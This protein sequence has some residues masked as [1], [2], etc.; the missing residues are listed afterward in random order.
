MKIRNK[1]LLL[2]ISFALTSQLVNSQ[3][4]YYAINI[5]NNGLP[6]VGGNYHYTDIYNISAC[7]GQAV[8]LVAAGNSSCPS[9]YNPVY[10]Y[11]TIPN[12]T[13]SN[14]FSYSQGVCVIPNGQKIYIK[15]YTI[16]STID[17]YVTLNVCGYPIGKPTITGGTNLC[18]GN[19]ISTYSGASIWSI[20]PSNAGTLTN[21][22]NGTCTISWSSSFI[23]TAQLTGQNSTTCCGLSALSDP[24]SIT[25]NSVPSSPIAS[26]SGITCVG[27]TLSLSSSTITGATYNWTGPNGY[28][29]T[30]QNPL[31]SDNASFLMA[32]NYT[33]TANVNGCINTP[34]T[35]S[36][37]INQATINSNTTVCEGTTLSLT[38]SNIP[39]ASYF[40]TG[41]NGFSSIDQNP[42][43]SL[44]VNSNMAGTYNVYTTANSCTSPVPGTIDIVVIPKPSTPIPSS[45]GPVC[46]GNNLSLS[47]PTILGATYQWTGPNSFSSTDQNPLIST[48]ASAIMGGI[49]NLTTTINGCSSN[50]S[51]TSVQINKIT[52]SSNGPV[53]SGKTLSLGATAIIGATYSWTGPNG[54]TS[55]QQNPIVSTNSTSAMAGVYNV[56]STVNGCTSP[57]SVTIVSINSS[58]T[59]PIITQNGTVLHS[60]TTT[61]NQWYNQNGII[62]GATNQNYTPTASGNYYV[63]VTSSPC[64]SSSSVFN[65]TFLANDEFNLSDNLKI[66]PNPTNSKISI[67]C[68]NQFNFLG[69]QIKITNLLGQDIF[70]S[71]INQQIIEI[72]LSSIATKGLYFVSIIDNLGKIITTKKIILN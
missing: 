49:Y 21:N 5:A 42:T 10:W 41:P 24:L 12:S 59:S 53:C 68:G 70:D 4:C 38:A 33:V 11:S 35:T 55:S 56:T 3:S 60:S 47:V 63:V 58:P 28:T 20:N 40:W 25:I 31:V 26:N 54:F 62:N 18:S 16:S 27:N 48:S 65:Y 50:A 9:G 19:N 7:G 30:E 32:G 71:K 67:D 72:Y 39:G 1:L 23:G 22:N 36:V 13:G 46:V 8:P 15:K 17:N 51:S 44:N 52:A 57:S 64:S 34:S 43:V 69:N 6:C 29:S 66:Y 2:S 37:I 14:Y 61:G 45:N